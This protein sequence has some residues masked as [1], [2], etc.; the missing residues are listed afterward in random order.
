MPTEIVP[1]CNYILSLAPLILFEWPMLLLQL[2]LAL[3]HAL[4]T[5]DRNQ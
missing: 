5:L 2:V 3:E 4:R 1:T